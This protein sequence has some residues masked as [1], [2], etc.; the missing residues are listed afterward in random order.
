MEKARLDRDNAAMEQIDEIFTKGDY[1]VTDATLVL[2]WVAAENM[3][4]LTD[5][6]FNQTNRSAMLQKLASA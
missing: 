2:L 6:Q 1:T 4:Y 5:F 3:A